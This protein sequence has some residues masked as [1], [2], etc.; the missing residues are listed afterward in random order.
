[1]KPTQKSDSAKRIDK[2]KEG[3]GRFAIAFAL[4]E[5]ADSQYAIAMETEGVASSIEATIS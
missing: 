3:D 4:M 2:A 5:L 1:L